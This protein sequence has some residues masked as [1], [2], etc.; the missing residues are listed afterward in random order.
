[1]EN[2]K[3]ARMPMETRRNLSF[4]HSLNLKLSMIKMIC[5]CIKVI[6]CLN[7]ARLDSKTSIKLKIAY[8][9]KEVMELCKNVNIRKPR[10][11]EQ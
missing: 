1:M 2:Q 9:A 11:L 10:Q 6:L 5:K 7:I 4:K 8:L 3:V